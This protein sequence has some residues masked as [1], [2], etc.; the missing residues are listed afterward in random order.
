MTR[1]SKHVQPRERHVYPPLLSFCPAADHTTNRW[2]CSPCTCCN[3]PRYK[4]CILLKTWAPKELSDQ[5]GV[6]K[7]QVSLHWAKWP[8]FS[9]SHRSCAVCSQWMMTVLQRWLGPFNQYAFQSRA[10][11]YLRSS[12]FLLINPPTHFTWALEQL[13]MCSTALSVGWVGKAV[14]ALSRCH[15]EN[16]G[17]LREMLMKGGV[18]A[19]PSQQE[20]VL[21]V[22][23]PPPRDF[24]CFD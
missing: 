7:V 21:G 9:C 14:K 13:V 11:F 16:C 2:N 15:P 10:S 6:S 4:L 24:M 8:S 22:A 17:N 23:H 5:G 12:A 1:V 3:L 20:Q 18:I 19:S